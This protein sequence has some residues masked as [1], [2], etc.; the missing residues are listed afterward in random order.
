MATHAGCAAATAGN[1]SLSGT[2][3]SRP[4]RASPVDARSSLWKNNILHHLHLPQN[5][6]R[7]THHMT[8]EQQRI[9]IAEACGWTIAKRVQPDAKL[10]AVM[11]WIRPGGNEWQEEFLPDYLNDLNAMAAVKKILNDDQKRTF[12]SKL[13][14]LANGFKTDSDPW[15]PYIFEA[16]MDGVA[17]MVLATAAQEAEAF[18]RALNLWQE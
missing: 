17:S 13:Y 5:R 10:H 8:P 16:S 4:K 15:T 14:D 12:A 1:S 7:F 2:S 11:C 6:G 9:A 18:L 3:T